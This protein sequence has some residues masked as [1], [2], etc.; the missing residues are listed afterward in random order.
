MPLR[1]SA[2][3]PSSM[4]AVLMS[5]LC[6]ENFKKEKKE[7][8]CGHVLWLLSLIGDQFSAEGFSSFLLFLGSLHENTELLCCHLVIMATALLFHLDEAMRAPATA[9]LVFYNLTSLQLSRCR[10]RPYAVNQVILTQ[11]Y[12]LFVA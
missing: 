5:T 12:I 9:T 7:T 11:I 6:L 4:E 3:A 10:R 2:T 1:T 8:H